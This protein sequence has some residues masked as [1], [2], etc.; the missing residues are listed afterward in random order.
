M[1]GAVGRFWGR[2]LVGKGICNIGREVLITTF[3]EEVGCRRELAIPGVADLLGDA[4][5]VMAANC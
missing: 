4:M 2:V 1:V 5:L 3:S